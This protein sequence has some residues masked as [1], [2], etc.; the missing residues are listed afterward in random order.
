M[1]SSTCMLV[2]S[3]NTLPL[4]EFI[5]SS[6][7]KALTGSGRNYVGMR[8]GMCKKQEGDERSLVAR[9]ATGS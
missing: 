5:I 4:K 8:W 3:E 1:G 2:L 7:L 9:S 6:S